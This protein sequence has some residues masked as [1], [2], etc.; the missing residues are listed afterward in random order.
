MG[1][2]VN[3]VLGW[4]LTNIKTN[5][6]KE[7]VDS[8]INKDGYLFR[9]GEYDEKTWTFKGFKKFW[10]DNFIDGLELSL[11]KE[12]LEYEEINFTKSVFY[13]S[14]F[15]LP[16]VLLITI[17]QKYRDSDKWHRWDEI[18]DFQ[19]E[20]F[21]HNQNSRYQ[22]YPF[23]IFPW[24]G[25]FCDSEGQRWVD[26]NGKPFSSIAREFVKTKINKNL[27]MS[28]VEAAQTYWAK[29]LGFDSIEEAD[30]NIVPILPEEIIMKCKYLQ[31]FNNNKTIYQLRPMLYVFW[32]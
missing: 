5:Q 3:K 22:I 30:R 29:M 18:I 7:I 25:S 16:E 11:F 32:R 13:N 12:F 21:N 4:G 19:E 1:L 6:D 23:G 9:D 8:R 10:Q 2:R 31:L 15:G 24:E 28:Q 14:E 17:S 26:Q 27:D 20:T